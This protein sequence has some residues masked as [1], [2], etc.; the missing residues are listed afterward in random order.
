MNAV[1]YKTGD[2]VPISECCAITVMEYLKS[3]QN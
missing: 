2:F 1:W 3:T